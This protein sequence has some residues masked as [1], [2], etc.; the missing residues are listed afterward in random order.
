MECTLVRL[1]DDGDITR[2]VLYINK[3]LFCVTLEPSWEDNQAYTSCIPFGMYECV[4]HESPNY[5]VTFKVKDVK[6]RTDILIHIGNLKGDSEGCI[7]LGCSYGHIGGEK[8]IMGSRIA[9]MEFIGMMTN[10]DCFVLKI[11]E[12]LNV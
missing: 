5:G 11:K 1:E 3:E 9:F 7:C 2:G 8:A 4:R 6:G 10:V 12:S